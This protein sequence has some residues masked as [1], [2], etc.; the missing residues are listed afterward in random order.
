MCVQLLSNINSNRSEISLVSENKRTAA[1]FHKHKSSR[2][3]IQTNPSA[4]RPDASL[5][6][7]TTLSIQTHKLSHRLFHFDGY[8]NIQ[9]RTHDVTYNPHRHSEVMTRL[10]NGSSQPHSSVSR[11]SFTLS[12][13]S[14]TVPYSLD[15]CNKE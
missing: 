15:C 2:Q 7:K 1:T 5:L 10:N 13:T 9:I 8:S 6:L 14:E 12:Q 11:E 4:D 3:L